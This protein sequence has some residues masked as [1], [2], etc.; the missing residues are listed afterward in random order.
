MA[1]P[2]YEVRLIRGAEDE[3]EGLYFYLAE[4]GSPAQANALLDAM[5]DK[6][7]ALERFPHRGAVPKELAGLGIRTFRQLVLAPY[8]ILYRVIGRDVFVLAIA[9][10]RRD[11]QAL[12][13]RRLLGR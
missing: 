3:L 9:D 7:E 5:L 4:H 12:L 13:E 6:V 10:G 2:H 8:R 11:M 1:P